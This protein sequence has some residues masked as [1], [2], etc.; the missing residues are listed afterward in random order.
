VRVVYYGNLKSLAVKLMSNDVTDAVSTG[1]RTL[2][3]VPNIKAVTSVPGVPSAIR[4]RCPIR[5]PAGFKEK[6]ITPRSAGLSEA[7]AFGDECLHIALD[8]ASTNH[9]PS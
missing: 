3:S 1:V 6:R 4:A 9:E 5:L 2:S 7:G 8:L